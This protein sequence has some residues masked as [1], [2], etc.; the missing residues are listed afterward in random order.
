MGP[1]GYWIWEWEER[2]QI[3]EEQDT[4]SGWRD[5]EGGHLSWG[6]K[7]KWAFLQGVNLG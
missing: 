6:W 7:T 4:N 2:F 5:R 1:L 3:I